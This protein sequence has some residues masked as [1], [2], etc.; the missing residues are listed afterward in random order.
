MRNPISGV[1]PPES[2]DHTLHTA[3]PIAKIPLR[4]Y[5][6]RASKKATAMTE[7]GVGTVATDEHGNTTPKANKAKAMPKMVEKAVLP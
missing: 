6:S 4:L 1:P 5:I 2:S 3:S 7:Q